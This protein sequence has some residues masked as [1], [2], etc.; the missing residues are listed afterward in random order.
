[1]R[2]D[3]VISYIK[4]L[5]GTLL[6]GALGSGLWDLVVSDFIAWLGT[7]VL[8]VASGV[9]VGFRNELYDRVSSGA[10]VSMLRLPFAVT[11][12]AFVLVPLAYFV[13][14]FSILYVKNRKKDSEG[15][16]RSSVQISRIVVRKYIISAYAI[17]VLMYF[18]VSFKY[19]YTANAA[20]QIEKSIEILAPYIEDKQ[21]L[22]LRSKFRS[23][24][25]YD[26]YHLLHSELEMLAK[27]H[28]LDL[29]GFEPI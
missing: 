18:F 8:E 14:L 1:M 2:R 9:S 17:T 16:D 28:Q 27:I 26:D 11:A 3:R 13:R 4:W 19:V 5:F 10:I 6:V 20:M 21:R 7:F 15:T 12:L 25:D 23:I 29:G 24:K 22:E